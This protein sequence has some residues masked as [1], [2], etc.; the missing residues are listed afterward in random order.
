[1]D[2]RGYTGEELAA[3]YESGQGGEAR[4]CGK[5]GTQ[6]AA[7]TTAAATRC[8]DRPRRSPL[9]RPVEGGGGRAAGLPRARGAPPSHAAQQPRQRRRIRPRDSPLRGGFRSI[10]GRPDGLLKGAGVPEGGRGGG[11]RRRPKPT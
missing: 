1:M 3:G 7:F 8:N 4:G 11:W 5:V 10:F 2:K 9:A 6:A